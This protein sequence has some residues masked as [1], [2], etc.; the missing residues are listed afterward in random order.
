MHTGVRVS[1]KL[2]FRR[3]NNAF[4]AGLSQMEGDGAKEH[5]VG[6]RH[7][8]HRCGLGMFFLEATTENRLLVIHL[9][10]GNL[11]PLSL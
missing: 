2:E 4:V 9:G 1:S 10:N 11:G 3:S 5:L 8:V 6:G 7:R